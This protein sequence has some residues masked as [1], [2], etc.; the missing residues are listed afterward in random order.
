M[1]WGWFPGWLRG[2]KKTPYPTPIVPTI[3]P[4]STNRT[5]WVKSLGGVLRTFQPTLRELQEV[6][7]E[8]KTVLEDEIGLD[9]IKQ[10]RSAVADPYAAPSAAH[11]P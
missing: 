2:S 4:S 6:S 3:P 10:E 9:E 5:Q 1:P 8:F 7:Q 11:F